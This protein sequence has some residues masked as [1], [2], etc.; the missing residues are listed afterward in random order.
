MKDRIAENNA[1]EKVG[2]LEFNYRVIL[3]IPIGLIIAAI[4]Y[5]I[6]FWYD[7][8]IDGLEAGRK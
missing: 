8:F 5:A 2:I 6:G 3:V 1:R 4:G 7:L